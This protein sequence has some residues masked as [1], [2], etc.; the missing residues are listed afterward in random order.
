M[1]YSDEGEHLVFNYNPKMQYATNYSCTELNF[2]RTTAPNNNSKSMEGSN[3]E[4]SALFLSH[5]F[6]DSFMISREKI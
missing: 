6:L 2:K 4:V 5:I 3:M 1:K